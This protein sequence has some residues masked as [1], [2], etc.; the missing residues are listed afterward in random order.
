ML[1][2]FSAALRR[3]LRRLL[4][5]VRSSPAR[6]RALVLAVLVLV[7][8]YVPG[9]PVDQ[10]DAVVAAVLVLA[11]GETGHRRSKARVDASAPL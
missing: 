1:R 6:V 10:L 8:M 5:V 3:V 7:S 11:A 4:G 9:L 2:K